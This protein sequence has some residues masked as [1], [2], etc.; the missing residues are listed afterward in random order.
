MRINKK[1]YLEKKY[2]PIYNDSVTTE[3]AHRK[4]SI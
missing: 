1:L 3:E 4:E 2:F